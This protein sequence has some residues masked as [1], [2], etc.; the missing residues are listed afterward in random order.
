MNTDTLRIL[1]HNAYWFQGHPYP[2]SEPGD[3]CDPVLEGLVDLYR[4]IDPDV[5]CLQEVQSEASFAAAVKALEYH[6][7]YCPG[8]RR[9]HYGGAMLWKRGDYLGDYRDTEAQPQ[10]VWQL[11]E[12]R[13]N[14]NARLPI[15]SVHLTSTRHIT[16]AEASCTRVADLA[17]MLERNPR[18][19]VIAGDFNEAPSG[20]SSA[21]LAHLGYVDTAT[22][23][24][25]A[26]EST[27]VNKSR[28]DQIWIHQELL[29]A[30][31][32]F[33]A[34]GWD[35]LR[36]DIPGKVALSDHLPLRIDLDVA[37]LVSL[38]IV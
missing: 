26:P 5:I 25:D 32:G 34:I 19:M 17:Q 16:E 12:A 10:R 35:R 1:S 14:G 2:D 6:G 22:L 36:C 20:S 27:G 23:V 29:P 33:E 21:F 37:T 3:P 18:P 4:N 7:Q 31:R 24:D 15:A 38:G 11:A 8:A 9:I 13:L 30:F 28:S